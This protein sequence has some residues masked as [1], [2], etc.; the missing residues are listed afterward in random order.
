MILGGLF[1]STPVGLWQQANITVNIL[2]PT[3]TCVALW[4]HRQLAAGTNL[5]GG[6][7]CRRAPWGASRVAFG[8]REHPNAA[9]EA[10]VADLEYQLRGA[11]L[12]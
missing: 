4:Q 6:S 9:V 7:T 8:S 12:H 3:P 2:L 5:V 11:D 10:S 1:H